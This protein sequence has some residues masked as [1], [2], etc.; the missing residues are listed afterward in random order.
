MTHPIAEYYIPCAEHPLY[1]FL[2]L[3]T[4]CCLFRNFDCIEW[5]AYMKVDYMYIGVQYM[6]IVMW[7]IMC[8]L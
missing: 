6:Y 5:V 3:G 1:I 2:K 4:Y 8:G 7:D